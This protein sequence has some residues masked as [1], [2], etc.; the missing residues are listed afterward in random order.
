MCLFFRSNKKKLKSNEKNHSRKIVI[1][2]SDKAS[3]I[4]P[5]NEIDFKSLNSK[6]YQYCLDIKI[7]NLFDSIPTSEFISCRRTKNCICYVYKVLNKELPIMVPGN[8]NSHVIIKHYSLFD[9]IYSNI[10][11]Y[12][13]LKEVFFQTVAY[14]DTCIQTPKIHYWGY[15]TYKLS[16]YIVM[17]YLDNNK[18][19]SFRNVILNPQRV[20]NFKD[21]LTMAS[22]EFKKNSFY[23]N[24][25]LNP[26]NIF[27]FKDKPLED[28]DCNYI[29]DFGEADI[30][31]QHP[32]I[33]FS[34]R[35]N[36]NN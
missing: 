21:Y 32:F 1:L 14:L 10:R 29:I 17:S 12:L 19:E 26:D 5:Q 11:K 4:E 34:P 27:T 20:K 25:L 30:R 24:D 23:H 2:D 15:N 7:D 9:D 35:G 33:I 13:L 22:N 31:D 28:K 18:F 6:S 3:I 8:E 16:F 36:F